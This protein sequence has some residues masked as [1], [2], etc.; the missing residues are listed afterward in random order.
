MLFEIEVKS[1]WFM[2]TCLYRGRQEC[3][4]EVNRLPEKVCLFIEDI[5]AQKSH[6]CHQGDRRT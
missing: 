5:E 1:A 6:V 2:D 4:Y 3:L